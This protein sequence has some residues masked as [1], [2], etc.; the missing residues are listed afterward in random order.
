MTTKADRIRWLASYSAERRALRE[1][2][3][4]SDYAI[5][6]Q[7][8]EAQ[9]LRYSARMPADQRTKRISG[10]RRAEVTAGLARVQDGRCY[11]CV[12]AGV[13]MGLARFGEGSLR[14][15]LEHVHPISRGGK[16]AGNIAAAH[17]KCDAAKGDRLPTRAELAALATINAGLA[18][19][20][21]PI[22]ISGDTDSTTI[23][24]GRRCRIV[25]IASRQS[26]DGNPTPS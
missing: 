14:A 11:I 20:P 17:A 25:T 8:A 13:D 23:G 5:W 15:V 21:P 7:I 3:A 18:P 9:T 12:A 22:S 6:L 4:P 16:N 24:S 1:Q 19:Q 10:P 2:G 26:V